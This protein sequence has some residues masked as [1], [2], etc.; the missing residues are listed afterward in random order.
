MA[1]TPR[2][3]APLQHGKMV[4]LT[5][6]TDS[7]GILITPTAT[8]GEAIH[9]NTSGGI[10][11]LYLFCH[12]AH[13]GSATLSLEWGGVADP[14]DVTEHGIAANGTSEVVSGMPLGSGKQLAGF[15][16]Q[17]DKMTVWGY[18]VSIG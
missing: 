11:L 4:A 5:G 17:A 1:D 12:N 18:A 8:A 10:Q 6:S 2:V 13:S 3:A 9:K 7:R 16:S 14:G 15:A